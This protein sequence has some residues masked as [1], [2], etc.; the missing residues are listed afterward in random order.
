MLEGGSHVPFIVHWPAGIKNPGTIFEGL[1]STLDVAATAV[2][3]GQG[4]T[5][6]KPLD[7][8]NLAPYLRGEKSGSPHD[9]LY[10]RTDGD[11]WCIR[12]PTMKLLKENWGGSKPEMYDMENDPYETKNIIEELPEKRKELAKM[13]NSW[14]EG[15]RANIWLQAGAYQ[16]KRLQMYDQLYKELEA[17]AA[18]RKPVIIK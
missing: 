16:K 17:K 1:V 8:V 13:W 5:S 7:G 15:N 9:A 2:A 10:W 14:N 18:K 11:A 12:T 6:G 4:D 3:L